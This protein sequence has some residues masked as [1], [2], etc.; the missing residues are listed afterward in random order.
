MSNHIQIKSNDILLNGVKVAELYEKESVESLEFKD[1]IDD[2]RFDEDEFGN[3]YVYIND[4]MYKNVYTN[5]TTDNT[6][7]DEEQDEDF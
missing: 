2:M 3:E 4:E 1:I 6:E 5:N 7:E